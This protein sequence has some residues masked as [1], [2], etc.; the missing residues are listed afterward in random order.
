MKRQISLM[1]LA[2]LL[3][4]TLTACNTV[5]YEAAV[6]A[7]AEEEQM[8]KRPLPI[9]DDE[10]SAEM[11]DTPNSTCFLSI[12][13]D[14]DTETLFVQFRDSGSVYAYDDVPQ[15]IYE[16]LNEADSMGGYY[17]EYI[18]GNYTAHRLS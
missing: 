13:Y 11:V 14:E 4:L 15:S 10:P 5:Q 18:K 8:S 2:F 9:E 6:I 3:A 1:L 7:K 12:G 17:N 16:E